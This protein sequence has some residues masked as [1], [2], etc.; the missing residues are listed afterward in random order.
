MEEAEIVKYPTSL[1]HAINCD[2]GTVRAVRFNGKN[3]TYIAI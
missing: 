1:L 3:F 2:Q